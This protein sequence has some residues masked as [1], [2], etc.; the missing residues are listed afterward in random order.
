MSGFL[1]GL[2]AIKTHFSHVGTVP[3]NS[4]S[5]VY[6]GMGNEETQID[7]HRG[8]HRIL[9]QHSAGGTTS[10]SLPSDHIGE[11]QRGIL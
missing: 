7:I 4:E 2:G 3:L 8:G 5:S 9:W 6:G 1:L 11:R 10:Q